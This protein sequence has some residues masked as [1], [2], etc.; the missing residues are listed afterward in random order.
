ML[1]EVQKMTPCLVCVEHT[2]LTFMA[3]RRVSLQSGL[4][5][6]KLSKLPCG[7]NGFVHTLDMMLLLAMS[8]AKYLACKHFCHSSN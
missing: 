8:I 6:L 2:L 7:E 5:V 3:A 4:V 1:R